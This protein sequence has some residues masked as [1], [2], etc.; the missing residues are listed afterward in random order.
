MVDRQTGI[1]KNCL[2]PDNSTDSRVFVQNCNK[3]SVFQTRPEMEADDCIIHRTAK[4]IT[5]WRKKHHIPCAN[6]KMTPNKRKT[7]ILNELVDNKPA[8]KRQKVANNTTRRYNTRL[9]SSSK[10]NTRLSL[11][12]EGEDN[13][14]DEDYDIDDDNNNYYV[15]EDDIAVAIS[16]VEANWKKQSNVNIKDSSKIEDDH[17]HVI[18][19]KRYPGHKFL[20]Y[21]PEPPSRRTRSCSEQ[22]TEYTAIKSF[23][24]H[25]AE[26]EGRGHRDEHQFE[27]SDT[28]I[29]DSPQD[30]SHPTKDHIVLYYKH[31]D[32]FAQNC[33][34]ALSR[35]IAESSDVNPCLI[36]SMKQ[37]LK[38][39]KQNDGTQPKKSFKF[40][41]KNH[42]LKCAK[43]F[44][45]EQKKLRNKVSTKK[46]KSRKK[47]E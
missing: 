14:N 5:Q 47:K 26:Y 1:T 8:R 39:W 35:F 3:K 17:V 2:L 44:I 45:Q 21:S 29:V 31:F 38:D 16:M 24:E 46:K 4:D 27:T 34:L 9:S 25:V 11:Y 37:F 15:L 13:E 19:F 33:P 7:E 6:K 32:T 20:I 42:L 12:E 18:W 36:I 28:T 43:P 40:N 30:L 22:Y 41:K 10:N 23:R